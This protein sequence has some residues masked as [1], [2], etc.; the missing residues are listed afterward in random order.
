MKNKL[1]IFC[2]LILICSTSAFAAKTVKIELLE[3]DGKTK[4]IGTITFENT[5]HG[6]LSTPKLEELPPGVHGFHVHTNPSCADNGMAAGGHYD[7][8]KTDKHLGP[9]NNQGHLGDMPVLIVDES[10]NAT[11][12][13]LAPRLKESDLTGRAIMIHAGGDNYSDQPN[14]LGGGGARLACGVA[15]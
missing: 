12:P 7:P 3:A 11:L 10:G 15:K 13:V 9:Y 6:L 2:S 14:K 1:A 4:S 5:S 8:A